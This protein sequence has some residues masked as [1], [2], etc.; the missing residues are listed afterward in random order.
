METQY[1]KRTIRNLI[2]FTVAMI[3]VGWL[4]WLL[5]YLGGNADSRGLGSLIWLASPLVISL[6]LRAFAGDGWKD[7]GI[8]PNFRGNLGWYL[9]SIIVY[10]FAIA[11][12]LLIGIVLGG[13]SLPEFSSTKMALF[14]SALGTAFI[15]NFIKN[16]FEEFSWRGY[17]APKI[18]TLGLNDIVAHLLVGVIWA[19]WHLP[20]YLGLMNAAEYDGYTSLSLVAFISLVFVALMT[21]SIAF[22]EIRFIT[23]STW[24]A[25]L[26]H[27]VSNT[28][29]LTLLIG[30]Y[31]QVS[32][33]GEVWFTPG[34]HGI[35]SIIVIF[36]IGIGLYLWRTRKMGSIRYG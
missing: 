28:V 7:I 33:A 9:V 31:I 25:V 22:D 5:G 1:R 4:G 15:V 12:V 17:L 3:V 14:I 10:P 11:V 2:I 26:M 6:L 16:I 24:P 19:I 34:M 32:R 18:F 13:I 8:K 23:G 29:I 35:L 20:Y 21:S 36:L 27:T 30:N